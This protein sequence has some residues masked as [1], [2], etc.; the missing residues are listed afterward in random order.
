MV[1]IC[2]QHKTRDVSDK[3]DIHEP[4]KEETNFLFIYLFIIFWYVEIRRI[5]NFISGVISQLI[6]KKLCFM[7]LYGYVA[8]QTLTS[9]LLFQ[10]TV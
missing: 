10:C 2:A 7:D 3:T 4:H 8:L 9:T 1:C 5:P 6:P